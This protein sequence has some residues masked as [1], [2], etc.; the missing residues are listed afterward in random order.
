M[1]QIEHGNNTT[2]ASR[3]DWLNDGPPVAESVVDDD[4]PPDMLFPGD[5]EPLAAPPM[6]SW[7]ERNQTFVWIGVLVFAVILAVLV[8]VVRTMTGCTRPP[9]RERP[10]SPP[11]PDDDLESEPEAKEDEKP[12]EEV[13]EPPPVSDQD[14]IGI[15]GS[16][17]TARADLQNLRALLDNNSAQHEAHQQQEA[18][19][20]ASQQE[21]QQY[22][23][24][25]DAQQYVPQ[26][27]RYTQQYGW[28]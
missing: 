11:P 17:K 18:Q 23:A 12:P 10:R 22:A 26:D 19:Q 25:P 20:Y 15:L 28:G 4:P 8:I 13:E 7:W 5:M 24:H 2:M 9:V 3:L 16:I 27:P 14:I 1:F 21:A 6:P